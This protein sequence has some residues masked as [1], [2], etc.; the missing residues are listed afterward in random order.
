LVK[1]TIKLLRNFW[2]LQ[3]NTLIL[4]KYC[5]IET[6]VCSFRYKIVFIWSLKNCKSLHHKLCISSHREEEKRRNIGMAYHDEER[7]L[8]P[9]VRG[10]Q[11]IQD[12]EMHGTSCCYCPKINFS[13][14]KA[15]I[16]L[17]CRLFSI[18]LILGS[19]LWSYPM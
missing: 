3:W 14:S 18:S 10:E 6:E 7:S 9:K 19:E 17:R 15:Y 4:I 2:S 16:H 12:V 5:F 8:N 1:F 11:L 13:M